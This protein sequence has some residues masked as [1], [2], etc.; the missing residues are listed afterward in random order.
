[1]L[2]N[3]QIHILVRQQASCGSGSSNNPARHRRGKETWTKQC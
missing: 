2:M 3:K 1:M